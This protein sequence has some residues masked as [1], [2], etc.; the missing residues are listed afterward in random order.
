MGGFDL[1]ALRVDAYS[2]E[3][4]GK[5]LHFKKMHPDMCRRGLNDPLILA[6]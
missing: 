6:A 1:N 5:G 2:F 3:S 4:G